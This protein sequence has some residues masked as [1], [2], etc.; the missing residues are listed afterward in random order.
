M[1]TT[2]LALALT[3][4]GQLLFEPGVLLVRFAPRV[5]EERAAECLKKAGTGSEQIHFDSVR[6]VTFILPGT[7]PD[8]RTGHG[9]VKAESERYA[10]QVRRARGQLRSLGASHVECSSRDSDHFYLKVA[11]SAPVPHVSAVRLASAVRVEAF[12]LVP[13]Y[14]PYSHAVRVRVPEGEETHWEYV[15]SQE[16]VVERAAVNWYAYPQAL[17]QSVEIDVRAAQ[18]SMQRRTANQESAERGRSG[19]VSR[20]MEAHDDLSLSSVL[21]MVRKYYEKRG[22]A[23]SLVAFDH[24]HCELVVKRMR[25]QVIAG[26]SY[27]ERLQVFLY[28]IGPRLSVVVQGK[29]APGLGPSFPP[30]AAFV[31]MEPMYATEL[32]EHLGDLIVHA[33]RVLEK[34]PP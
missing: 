2:L 17:Q 20:D 6:A 11:F 12:Y 32:S 5:T 8:A 21:S 15:L 28:V 16:D 7:C 26:K 23:A 30:A 29:Y 33:K 10:R 1:V 3:A 24:D 27:W 13:E 22:A 14:E 18:Q 25:G 9:S 4:R 19:K 31:D 34:G